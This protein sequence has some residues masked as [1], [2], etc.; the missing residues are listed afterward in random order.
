MTLP[1][2]IPIP[3]HIIKYT[4]HHYFQF[5]QNFTQNDIQQQQLNPNILNNS[6]F[7]NNN[8]K[9]AQKRISHYYSS[10][11]RSYCSSPPFSTDSSYCSNT[12]DD[13]NENQQNNNPLQE[14]DNPATTT[15]NPTQKKS[16]QARNCWSRQEDDAL[17]YIMENSSSNNTNEI[18]WSSVRVKFEQMTGTKRNTRQ[19]RTRYRHVLDPT[20]NRN[21]WTKH[22]IAILRYAYDKY[23]SSWIKIASLLPGRSDMAVK[24]IWNSMNRSQKRKKLRMGDY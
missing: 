22:E 4:I 15:N 11:T 13:E 5:I 16:Y 10:S 19:I 8:N 12:S 2:L 1:N 14:T 17:K 23:G 9:V 7:N 3:I 6:Q 20:I 18:S 24:N 21:P